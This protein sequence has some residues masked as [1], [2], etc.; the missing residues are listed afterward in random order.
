MDKVLL[1]KSYSAKLLKSIVSPGLAV[2][3]AFCTASKVLAV[4]VKGYSL[5]LDANHVMF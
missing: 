1:P 5:P 3:K 2:S 4:G